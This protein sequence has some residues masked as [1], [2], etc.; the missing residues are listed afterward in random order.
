MLG[1][2]EGCWETQDGRNVDGFTMMVSPPA[3]VTQS[4]DYAMLKLHSM[5]RC[6]QLLPLWCINTYNYRQKYSPI[7][8]AQYD[9]QMEDNVWTDQFLIIYLGLYSSFFVNY[10][11]IFSHKYNFN[12]KCRFYQ[13]EIQRFNLN[14]KISSSIFWFEHKKV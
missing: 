13:F 4:T 11:S 6:L 10:F 7:A 8:L 14:F 2:R 5:K 9:L 12:L 3:G 1:R